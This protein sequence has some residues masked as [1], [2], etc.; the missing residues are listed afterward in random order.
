M[1]IISTVAPS[2]LLGPSCSP[3]H[4]S[5]KKAPH[6][7]C[8]STALQHNNN[9]NNK[10]RRS[11][12]QQQRR[13]QQRRATEESRFPPGS[14][15]TST[16]DQ[17]PACIDAHAARGRSGGAATGR[18]VHRVGRCRPGTS[19]SG[20]GVGDGRPPPGGRDGCAPQHLRSDC[21]GV[22][23]EGVS[24]WGSWGA[25][26]CFC[27]VGLGNFEKSLIFARTSMCEILNLATCLYICLYIC[28]CVYV[29]VFVCVHFVYVCVCVF[30]FF[31]LYFYGGRRSPGPNYPLYNRV[32]SSLV[33]LY[34]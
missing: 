32:L 4:L 6:P 3:Y 27:V 30:V 22:R 13:Q 10:P 14:R 2:L 31:L 7:S 1:I 19:A 9:A 20:G 28:M 25:I 17:S 34:F 5:K 15:R 16:R 23:D 26:L 11:N 12:S 29:C 8:P 21:D 33:F 24:S 18:G